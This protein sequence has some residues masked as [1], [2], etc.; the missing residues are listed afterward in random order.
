MHE[1]ILIL[2][3]VCISVL[4]TGYF[5]KHDIPDLKPTKKPV[6]KKVVKSQSIVNPEDA[7]LDM[8]MFNG[9]SED[10]QSIIMKYLE[11]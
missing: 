5:V 6:Y 3:I 8:E 11:D 2:L 10:V 1:I 7:E 9:L 4:P